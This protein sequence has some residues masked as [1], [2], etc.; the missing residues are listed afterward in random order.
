MP[1]RI[2]HWKS[3]SV[4]TESISMPG[5][6]RSLR[7]EYNWS[8]YRN[9]AISDSYLVIQVLMICLGF[10]HSNCVLKNMKY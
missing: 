9:Y 1:N 2:G 4:S 7:I 10:G 6:C 3:R 8:Y 5:H